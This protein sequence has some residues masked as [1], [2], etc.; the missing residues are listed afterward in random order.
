MLDKNVKL[1]IIICLSAFSLWT[2]YTLIQSYIVFYHFLTGVP[3]FYYRSFY[4][5]CAHFGIT[6]RFVGVL[7]AFAVA[8]I[9]WGKS[10]PFSKTKFLLAAALVLEGIYFITLI[11]SALNLTQGFGGRTFFVG[12]AYFLQ[13]IF[14][15]PVLFLASFKTAR[16]DINNSKLKWVGFVLTG[17]F[18][19]LWSNSVFRW[20]D[21]ASSSGV[22][23][24]LTG[25]PLVGF[26][27]S[28]VLFSL[29]IILSVVATVYLL[30]DRINAALKWF[31]LASVLVGLHYI[32]FVVYSYFANSL[33]FA[34]LVEVWAIPLFGL[35]LAFLK[36]SYK[37]T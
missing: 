10:K 19:A 7:L 26:L 16:F 37:V 27:N 35:G 12:V 28:A 21:M 23:F 1:W 30:K 22:Q 29:A 34:W 3:D 11:P 13:V 5:W 36:N 20:F 2:V 25:L 8:F 4:Y 14:A 24:L 9:S 32:V 15:A 17:Y 18:L 33:N 31:S 6:S